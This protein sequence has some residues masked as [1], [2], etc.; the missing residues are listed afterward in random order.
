M[1]EENVVLLRAIEPR[2]LHLMAETEVAADIEFCIAGT[3]KNL[4]GAAEFSKV[5]SSLHRNSTLYHL[6]REVNT[7]ELYV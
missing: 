7:W 2:I 5:L 3:A 4:I 1:D 6:S